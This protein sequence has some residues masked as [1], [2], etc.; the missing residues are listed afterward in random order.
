MEKRPTRCLTHCSESNER[1]LGHCFRLKCMQ[2]AGKRKTGHNDFKQRERRVFVFG[3][4]Q[5]LGYTVILQITSADQSHVPLCFSCFTS[6]HLSFA[7]VEFLR[8][9]LP[10]RQFLKPDKGGGRKQDT[11][12]ELW[13]PCWFPK[14]HT[15][16]KP[17]RTRLRGITTQDLTFNWDFYSSM[18][19]NMLLLQLM[20]MCMTQYSRSSGH[21]T[22][23]LQS[24]E[25]FR[26]SDL[27]GNL[28]GLACTTEACVENARLR[29]FE[30]LTTHVCDVPSLWNALKAQVMIL[31]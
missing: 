14:I 1:P 25:V 7:Y 24:T 10:Y 26:W 29:L 30:F 6:V 15:C 4:L 16:W 27:L 5:T 19:T 12:V 28:G 21:F 20:C 13:C 3:L 23:R 31:G 8:L 2:S 9:T 11:A 18:K 22:Q 17:P